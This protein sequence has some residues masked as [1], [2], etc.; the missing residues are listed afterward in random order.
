VSQ[1]TDETIEGLAKL[2]LELEDAA[3]KRGNLGGTEER[4][5][6]ASA[7]YERAVTAASREDLL[8]AWRAAV[9]AQAECEM[10]SQAWSEARA[11]SEL[12]RV[13]YQARE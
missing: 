4:A 13:E 7:A 6:S 1:Q 9:K 2:W 8:L 5:R 12:L 11:I 3:S 10:G